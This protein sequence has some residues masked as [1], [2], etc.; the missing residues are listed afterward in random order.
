MNRLLISFALVLVS[1]LP[2][3]A[4]P[5]T[6][7]VDV[8]TFVERSRD[9]VIARCIRPDLNEGLYIDG[10]HPA[11]VEVLTVLQGG[12]SPGKMRIATVYDLEAGE[13][14]LLAC[15]AGGFAYETD[16]M[17]IAERSVVKLPANFRTEDLKGKKLTEQVQMVFVAAGLPERADNV[18]PWPGTVMQLPPDGG[19]EFALT[20]VG[21]VPRDEERGTLIGQKPHERKS[22]KDRAEAADKELATLQGTWKL[23]TH[24][25]QGTV[26]APDDSQVVTIADDKITWR[27]TGAVIEEGRIE[28]EATRSPKHLN[29]QF[30]SGRNDQT[31]YIRVGDYLIQC[32]R[33]DRKTRPSE[34][35]TGTA[36]GGEYLIIL[37][38]QM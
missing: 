8:P 21:I 9:I 28:L 11:E 36:N 30:N 10:L 18:D 4:I 24:E 14:Y 1:P 27:R 6:F 17:A 33:R 26:L 20:F 29:Y 5:I 3:K 13:T 37:K 35:A 12:K 25:E 31:I 2:C 16:F 19:T 23:Q 22:E 38:R 7:F 15:G 32:G 34:F